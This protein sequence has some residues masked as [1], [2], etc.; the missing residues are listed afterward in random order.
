VLQFATAD[1]ERLK[2]RLRRR[3]AEEEQPLLPLLQRI[4]YWRRAGLKV[5]IVCG[6]RGQALRL[7]EL[8]Q[9]YRLEGRLWE[10]PFR[11]EA[12]DASLGQGTG[13][14]LFVGPVRQGFLFPRARLAVL[15]EEEIFGPKVRRSRGRKR[16]TLEEKD[17]YDLQEG[18]FVV[19]KQHG[20]A[21]YRGLHKLE[22]GGVEGDFLL[23]EYQGKDKL[24]LPVTR[25][26]LI[27]RYSGGLSKPTLDRLGGASFEKKKG[28]VRRGV[29]EM[30]AELIQ[31]YAARQA[32]EGTSFPSPDA[33][34]Q[35]FEARFPFEETPD[36]LR[37]IEDVLGDMQGPRCMD[38][39]VC[40]DVGYGKTEVA[41]RAAFHAVYSGR[42]VAVL[43]PTTVLAQQH[44]LT[45]AERLEGYP[46]TTAKVRP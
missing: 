12:I 4:R 7:R 16:R 27:T 31:L 15:S 17:L 34:Y 33:Y 45:F 19:H 36:Q 24:Y 25:L 39:L 32:L 11:Y 18:D 23:L 46:L 20:M 26:S 5:L 10:E 21:R 3:S 30:A 22:L 1:Q 41:L 6:S 14:D 8:L 35:D 38:R 42:Q 13:V 29:L 43:V 37:A 44:G 2:G 9:P 28:K 40:G